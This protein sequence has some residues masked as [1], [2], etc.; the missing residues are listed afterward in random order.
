MKKRI[1]RSIAFI[2]TLFMIVMITPF[3]LKEMIVSAASG[4]S[5]K[6]S[7][8]AYTSTTLTWS[9]FNKTTPITISVSNSSMITDYSFNGNDTL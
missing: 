3:A 6:S 5:N 4:P 1:T 8:I 2:T 7:K 9:G